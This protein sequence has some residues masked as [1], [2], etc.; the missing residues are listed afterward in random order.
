MT[1]L[2]T[3]TATELIAGYALRNL[4]D[5]LSERRLL[6]N[7]IRCAA[8]QNS[9]PRTHAAILLRCLHDMDRAQGQLGLEGGSK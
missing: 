5:S 7:A 4:P 3:S 2:P 6:L 1:K 9:E 8:P